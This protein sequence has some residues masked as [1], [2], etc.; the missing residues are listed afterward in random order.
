MVAAAEA[1]AELA[2]IFLRLM[3]L[4]AASPP[5]TADPPPLRIATNMA[6]PCHDKRGHRASTIQN[7]SGKLT[8][9]SVDGS[10]HSVTTNRGP[11]SLRIVSGGVGGAGGWNTVPPALCTTYYETVDERYVSRHIEKRWITK[12]CCCSC[13]SDT[14]RKVISVVRLAG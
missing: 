3:V 2:S 11:E 12:R 7:G 9:P 4:P 8:L 10:I 14:F 6:P 1:G 13:I 5:A